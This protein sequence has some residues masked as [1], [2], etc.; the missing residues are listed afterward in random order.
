MKQLVAALERSKAA[1]SRLE[2]RNADLL[3][4]LAD[5]ALL[6]G[7]EIRTRHGGLRVEG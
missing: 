2:S 6:I 4:Q 7:R 1:R 5:G 3:Q